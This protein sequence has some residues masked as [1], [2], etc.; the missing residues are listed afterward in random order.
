M[1]NT[2]TQIEQELR[3][4]TGTTKYYYLNFLKNLKFTDGMNYFCNRLQCFWLADIFASVQHLPQIKENQSFILW[5]I[6]VNKNKKATVTAMTGDYEELYKQ[7]IE[8]TDLP[9]IKFD[10][11]QCNDVVLLT[12]EY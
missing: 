6:E 1:I 5:R 2:Q 8:Y 4:F 12:N 11:Y 10:C 9:L 7:K 3:N